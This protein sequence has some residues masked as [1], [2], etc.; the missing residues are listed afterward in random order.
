[1]D[2]DL[3]LIE[4]LMALLQSSS[5]DS[6]EVTE[7]DMRI[8]LSKTGLPAQSPIKPQPAHTKN[9]TQ[10][11]S[12]PEEPR[13]KMLTAGMAGT[14]YRAP[15]PGAAPFVSEGQQVDEGDRLALIESMKML[16]PVEAE[17]PG[18]IRQI[19]VQDGSPVDVGTPLFALE[20]PAT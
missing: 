7:G 17:A 14:F 9:V 6:L 4:R 15:S 3:E 1:M 10:T 19:L 13:L 2:V 8:R 20:A 11:Q 12:R 18:I 16:N 5:L